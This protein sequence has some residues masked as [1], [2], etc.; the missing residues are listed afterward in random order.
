MERTDAN[1]RPHQQNPNSAMK[2]KTACVYVWGVSRQEH[3][4]TQIQAKWMAMT[5]FAA[6]LREQ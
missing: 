1:F 3:I 6:A 4:Q 2:F 5:R